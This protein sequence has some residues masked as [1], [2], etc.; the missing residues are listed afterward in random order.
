MRDDLREIIRDEMRELIADEIHDVAGGIGQWS[1][2]E[3]LFS[4]P[5]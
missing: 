2:A 1:W 4:R 3:F 5:H